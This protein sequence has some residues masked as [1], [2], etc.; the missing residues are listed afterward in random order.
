[1]ADDDDDYR[2]PTDKEIIDWMFPDPDARD[3]FLE[4]DQGY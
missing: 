1:M 2:D 4:G 3:E